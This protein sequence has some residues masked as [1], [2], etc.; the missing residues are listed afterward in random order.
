MLRMDLSPLRGAADFRWLLCS[1][2]VTL[3]GTEASE[4]ALLVQAK[5]LTGSAFAV[6]LL[7]VAELV[8][9][10][11]F[12]L[13]G[14]LLADRVDRARLLRWGEAGLGVL[15][16]L[17]LA[18][19]VLP[20]PAVWPLYVLAAAMTTLTALQ[21]PSFDAAVP[22]TV[23]RDQLPGAA[24]LLGVSGNT[25]MIIGTALGG[26]LAAGP[27]PQ[28][29]YGWDT[30]SFLVSLIVLT[31]VRPLPAMAGKA[32]PPAERAAERVRGV[33]AGFH[34]ARKRP[35][36]LGSYLA[37]LAAMTLAYPVALFPFLAAQLHAPWSAG[38]MFAAPSAGAL[39]ASALSGWA[40]RVH[41][42]GLAIAL[43]A[44]GWGLAV[45][46]FGFAPDLAAAL[47]CLL[48]A[49]AA[50]E[51][52]GIFRSTLWNQTVPDQLRGRLAGVELLS[53]SIG[54]SAGQLRAGGVASLTSP[55]IA[56]WSGGLLC[57]GAVGLVCLA[58]PGFTRYSSRA[59]LSAPSGG[60]A[61]HGPAP[62]APAR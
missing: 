39:A 49:G 7:G 56:A 18:N 19:A 54:P 16:A 33:L 51:I 58:L 9:L 41:R 12:G 24:A 37:D 50:D 36:L 27:G 59:S 43:A 20:D 28:L 11:V 14:G 17:L 2:T 53:Y 5:Q 34:Y 48:V 29:V 52:S 3:L 31:R 23:P 1:R 21:R 25:S 38:L 45:T 42:H 6:G 4:V 57:V 61:P 30:A 35:E 8:P 62:A 60:A 32:E 46:A 10:V 15:A 55:R 44:A 13:Y 40:G 22:R 26:V 47:A